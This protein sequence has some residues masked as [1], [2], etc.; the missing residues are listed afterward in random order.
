MR[1]EIAALA[2]AVIW[3]AS[4][5]ALAATDE[6]A[7]GWTAA[8]AMGQTPDR[9]TPAAY[10]SPSIAIEDSAPVEPAP[11]SRTTTPS[12]A[13]ATTSPTPD[14][15][16]AEARRLRI[17]K[18]ERL[19][20]QLYPNSGFLPYV[21]F[22][23]DEHARLG[24][25]EAWWW[26]LVYGGANFSLRV[27]GRAPG[28]CC[29]PLDVKGL[30]LATDPHDNIRRHCAEM[31]GFWRRGVRGRDLCESVFYPAAPRDWGGGRFRRT[32][33]R[34]RACIERGYRVGKL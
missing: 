20:R 10:G 1:S 22:F 33:A 3:T 11:T 30:P 16:A 12:R 23:I 14:L 29:G 28:N 6:E 7:T 17:A 5:W 18:C 4:L 15:L 8:Y 27:G 25:P 32:D 21:E 13:L 9:A 2:V 34:H 19:V 31:A 26:S 24:M